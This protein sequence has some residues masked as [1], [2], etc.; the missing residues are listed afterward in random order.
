MSDWLTQILRHAHRRAQSLKALGVDYWKR[1]LAHRPGVPC[2]DTLRTTSAPIRII[3]EFK[4]ASPSAGHLR[5][6]EDL[7][8]QLEAYESGGAAAFSILTE[9]LVFGGTMELVWTAA[10]FVHRPILR[11]DFIVDP[12]QLME[13][14]AAG[15][16]AVLLIH[17]LL[18]RPLR[19]T[20]M[21][22][23]EELQLGVLYEVFTDEEAVEGLELGAQ[24]IGINNRDLHTLEMDRQRALRVFEAVDWPSGVEIVVESGIENSQD[25]RR[26]HKAGLR[27]FL[28]GT[29]LMQA[30]D[31][32]ALLRTFLS[33]SV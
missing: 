25:I 22:M 7:R 4:P 24:W 14:A 6:M 31:P 15:A 8:Q 33:E 13:A 26:Y 30:F 29:V 20:L 9:P 32:E 18:E 19:R 11:K 23:A 2:W 16:S 21:R 27:N 5:S 3:A 28:I 12:I 10:R 1:R 17:R